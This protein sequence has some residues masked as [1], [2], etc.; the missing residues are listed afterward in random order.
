MAPTPVPG[1]KSFT[2]ALIYAL[3]TLVQE[4]PQGRFTTVDLLRRIKLCPKFA[5]DQTP[6]LSDREDDTAPGRIMFH[7]LQREGSGTHTPSEEVARP[8]PAK[9][10]TITLHFDF[11]ETPSD[12]Y[13]ERLGRELNAIFER[14]A[15]GVSR[16]RWGGMQSMVT[17]AAKGFIA[18][19]E[20]RRSRNSMTSSSGLLSPNS[21][22]PRTPS[23]TN[24]QTVGFVASGELV[25]DIRKTVNL[26]IVSMALDSKR[27][28][29]NLLQDRRGRPGK[30]RL[31]LT[32]VDTDPINAEAS[33]E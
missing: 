33:H 12:T 18:G 1:E 28:Y 19:L 7:P 11:C 13:I 3:E 8:D 16:V 29:E 4:Q 24:S 10:Q 32:P 22:G 15:M 2:S 23:P 25:S 30:P 17:R 9:R 27:E 26:D 21:A 6:V 14:H 20:R 31:S 5:K